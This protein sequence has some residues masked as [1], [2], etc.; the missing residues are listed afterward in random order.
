MA[1][2]NQF[3]ASQV[4]LE[5]CDVVFNLIEMSGKVLMGSILSSAPFLSTPS[6]ESDGS[7]WSEAIF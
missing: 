2:T 5:G 1:E 7:F 4:T 3:G 6:N